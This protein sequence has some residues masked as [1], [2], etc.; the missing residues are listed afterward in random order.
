MESDFTNTVCACVHVCVVCLCV[1]VHVC[2]HIHVFSTIPECAGGKDEK[3]K[4]GRP[5][6]LYI[7]TVYK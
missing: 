2:M 5:Q 3:I 4:L 7:E 6:F 1:C